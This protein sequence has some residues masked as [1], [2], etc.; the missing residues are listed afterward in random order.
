[1]TNKNNDLLLAILKW[2]AGVLGTLY[3][4]FSIWL[5]S[6]VAEIPSL[7]QRVSEMERQTSLQWKQINRLRQ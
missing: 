4:A 6:S 1:M 5:V 7:E 2:I 3:V